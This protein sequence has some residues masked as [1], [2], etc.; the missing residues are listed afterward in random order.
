MT[1]RT[2]Y[3]LS[4][5]QEAIG[6]IRGLLTGVSFE[7]MYA[8]PAIKAAFE[9]FLEI[10]SE[11]SRHLPIEL[12]G[13]HPEVPWRNVADLGNVLRHTYHKSDARALWAIY[14]HELDALEKAVVAMI[15]EVPE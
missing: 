15:G 12:T 7:E 3:R 11:A 6:N 13:R 14:E 1:R 5:I 8:D 2:K 4:D 9:R 10:A